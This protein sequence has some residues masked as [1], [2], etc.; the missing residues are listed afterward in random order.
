M[1]R[2]DAD[3]FYA[4]KVS[5]KVS[6]D[7]SSFEFQ[8]EESDFSA[9]VDV[10]MHVHPE[11]RLFGASVQ[12]VRRNLDESRTVESLPRIPTMSASECKAHVAESIP[13][14]GEPAVYGDAVSAPSSCIFI[15]A[16]RG[17]TLERETEGSAYSEDGASPQ[18]SS[19]TTVRIS[20]RSAAGVCMG[21]GRGN[22]RVD[23]GGHRQGRSKGRGDASC[24]ANVV[25][26]MPADVFL[27][28]VQSELRA[29]W[30][31]SVSRFSE[32]FSDSPI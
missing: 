2:A 3:E 21:S 29:A 9:S 22:T 27:Q 10:P 14:A 28:V 6:V 11:R 31:E 23:V 18:S 12:C 4:A 16:G 30:Q 32:R 24:S 19:C 7:W 26:S 17:E 20:L 8:L 13:V 15:D 25:P 5:E 1:L